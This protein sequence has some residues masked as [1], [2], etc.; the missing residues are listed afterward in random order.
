VLI[1]DKYGLG[2]LKT[3]NLTLKKY[4]LENF[5]KTKNNF[6][7]FN[8]YVGIEV[9]VEN[10]KDPADPDLLP[11]F[12][13]FWKVGKDGSL[14]DNGIEL[15][16]VPLRGIN[17]SGAIN[18]LQDFLTRCYPKHKFSH[19]CGVHVHVNCREYEEWQVNNIMY[20]YCCVETLLFKQFV[21]NERD[22]NSFCMPVNDV[23]V[24]KA[25]QHCKYQAL[26]RRSLRELGTLEFRHLLGT[27]NQDTLKKWIK[28]IINLINYATSRSTQEV[29]DIILKLN[30]LSNYEAFI[31]DVLGPNDFVKLQDEMEQ[32]VY[33]AKSIL[34]RNLS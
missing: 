11:N 29:T 18:F 6:V 13:D 32:D 23:F 3:N 20:V 8:G 5:P 12:R 27:T 2:P 21:R 7:G 28:I 9:E 14:R 33:I 1:R 10:I 22:G 19:R 25:Y 34:G 16:S 17:I 31:K 30:T 24:G 26:N 4:T 15:I